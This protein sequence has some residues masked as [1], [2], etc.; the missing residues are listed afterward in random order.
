MNR[1]K[2]PLNALI[3]IA[4]SA[5]L[6]PAAALFSGSA[7]AQLQDPSATQNEAA[8]GGRNFPV[9]T[10]RGKFMVVNAPE[11]QL[12]GQAERLSPGARILGS[13]RMLVMPAAITGQNLLVNYTRDAA[14]LVREVW[15]L[16]PDEAR[17][18]RASAEKPLLNFWPFVADSGPRDDGKTPFDQLPRYGQ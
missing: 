9:G 2:N 14:G 10:L 3:L 7:A 4:L 6:V 17:A 5:M 18:K 12:D 15:I 11:I 8:N 16:T 1:C 13:N